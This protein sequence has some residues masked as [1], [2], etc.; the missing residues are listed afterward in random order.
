MSC[1]CFQLPAGVNDEIDIFKL[2][3]F[4]GSIQL[5]RDVQRVLTNQFRAKFCDINRVNFMEKLRLKTDS[6]SR[7]T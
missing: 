6:L 7:P 3:I 2:V 4:P 5:L 1:D